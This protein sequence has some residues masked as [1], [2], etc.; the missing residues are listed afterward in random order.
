MEDIWER[1]LQATDN[2]KALLEFLQQLL[3]LDPHQR[4]NFAD[5]AHHPYLHQIDLPASDTISLSVHDTVAL[6]TVP[7]SQQMVSTPTISKH[8][9]MPSV[10]KDVLGRLL[11]VPGMPSLV[12]DPSCEA[13]CHMSSGSV[14]R[15]AAAE[16]MQCTVCHVSTPPLLF[17]AFVCMRGSLLQDKHVVTVPCCVVVGC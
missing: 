10:S 9:S 8:V 12:W 13:V 1:L 17:N 15:S 3:T 5:L 16:S 4:A 2:D 11:P 7:A 6:P 14:Y